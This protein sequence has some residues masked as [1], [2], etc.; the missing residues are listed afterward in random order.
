METE[1]GTCASFWVSNRN[2]KIDRVIVFALALSTVFLTSVRPKTT[3]AS[4]PSDNAIVPF[5]ELLKRPVKLRPVLSGQHPR[6]FFTEES[7][8]L[9]R[10]RA[11][12]SDRELWQSVLKDV[13]ALK[14]SPPPPGAPMLNRSGVEQIEGD[15]SQYDVAYILAEVTHAYAIEQDP[16]F[17]EA[18]RHWLL[19][20]IKY[21]PWGY[22]FRT[23]NVDLPPAHLLYA[24]AFAYDTLYNQ[25]TVA[26]R[27]AVRAK[28][29]RQ[30][31]LMYQ[32]FQYKT[33]KK[34][35]YSQPHLYSDGR[36]RHSR[37]RTNGRGAGSGGVGA[38]GARGF[39]SR[40]YNLRH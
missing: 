11:Q 39:R 3:R 40:A 36:I 17:L 25:L 26:E 32:F 33:R 38:I 20:I 14:I 7:L 34:Y 10:I 5:E 31:R 28:L 8:K 6:V 4:G 29:A 23:P 18:A 13:R 27:D 1:T 12:T 22:T 21:D 19:A 9:L 2:R 35:S 37:L 16:R 30:A 24:V 15:F